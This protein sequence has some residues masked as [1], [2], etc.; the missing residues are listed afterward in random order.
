ML[1]RLPEARKTFRRPARRAATLRFGP[2]TPLVTCV[3][4]DISKSGARLAVAHPLATLPHHF[5]LNLY[6]NGNVK[7]DCEVVWT[8]RRF[9]GVKFAEQ[10]L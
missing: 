4:W 10:A 5:S 9:V 3:I 2:K 8:D 6:K 7:W 1:A